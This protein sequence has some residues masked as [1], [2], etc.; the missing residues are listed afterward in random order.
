MSIRM[1]LFTTVGDPET[2]VVLLYLCQLNDYE[3]LGPSLYTTK[4]KQML[5]QVGT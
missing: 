2:T 1:Y 3:P 4:Q 5:L